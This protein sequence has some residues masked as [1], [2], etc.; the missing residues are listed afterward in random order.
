M[1]DYEVPVFDRA[2]AAVAPLCANKK[3]VSTVITDW[4]TAFPA[5][6]LI[7]MDNR[8]VR[9][10]NTSSPTEDFADIVYQAEVFDTTKSGC[11]AVFTALDDAMIAM[12]FSRMSGQYVNNWGNPKVFR[13]VARYEALVDRDGNLYRRR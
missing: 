2:Y 8:T 5:A 9:E 13:Y 10:K 6:S 12:N 11:K 1:I 3:F 4:P 7:E